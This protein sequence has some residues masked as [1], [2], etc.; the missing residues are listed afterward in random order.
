LTPYDIVERPE[1]DV[2][3]EGVVWD[4]PA[5][6]LY[7]VDI[8]GK[9]AHRL[10]PTTGAITRWDLPSVVSF[11]GPAASG[12]LVAALKDGAYSLDPDTGVVAP[13]ARPDGDRRNRS[14]DCRIDPQGRLWLGAMFDSSGVDGA[15]HEIEGPT[16]GL[17]WIDGQGRSGRLLS[18]VTIPNALAFTPDGTRVCFA[19]TP[20]GVVWTYAVDPFGG[21]GGGPALHDRRVLLEGGPGAPDG[22]AMDE[23]GCLWNARWGAGLVARITPDGR[24]DRVVELPVEQPSCCAFGG[25]DGRTLYVTTAREG[26]A[27]LAPDALDGALFAVPVDVA[28]MPTTRFAD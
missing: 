27:G 3:G 21:E 25:A 12:K 5:G 20:R 28:G 9:R 11:V 19:D 8:V 2:L 16:G 15:P 23:A 1:R 17:F 6:V 10:D 22:A 14:N 26:L 7:W 24:I 13:I 4:A 18:D